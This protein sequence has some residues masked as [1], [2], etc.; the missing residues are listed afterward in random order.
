MTP[1][2]IESVRHLSFFSDLH[3]DTI[4]QLLRSSVMQL[5]P[6]NTTLVEQ[7]TLTDTLFLALA[8]EVELTS[9]NSDAEAV[10]AIVPPGRPFLLAT[11]I[12]DEPAIS[13][14]K[15]LTPSSV[16][17]IPANMFRNSVRSDAVLAE[18]VARL[19]AENY[20]GLAREMNNHKMRNGIQRVGSWILKR[21]VASGEAPSF[22]LGMS[23]RTLASLLGLT[24]E[25]LSRAIGQIASHGAQMT[26]STVTLT[27]IEALKRLVGPVNVIEGS[28]VVKSIAT[29]A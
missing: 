19:M 29:R 12:T 4:Q 10:I 21:Y 26:G 2:E 1:E 15:T 5:L 17:M 8:T 23:K 25:S 14:A 16:I 13:S 9:R 20:I 11:V 18:K 7:D 24:P 28:T 27:D 22:P 3:P 6:A